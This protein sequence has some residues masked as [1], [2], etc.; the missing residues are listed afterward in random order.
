MPIPGGSNGISCDMEEDSDGARPAHAH[1]MLGP[2]GAT[3]EFL[4]NAMHVPGILHMLG[5]I[6]KDM[7]DQLQW[8]LECWR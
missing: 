3:R 5:N 1:A 8:R 6:G 7:G 2:H 4:P